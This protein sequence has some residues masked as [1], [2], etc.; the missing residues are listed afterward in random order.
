MG[1][2]TCVAA[3]EGCSFPHMSSSSSASSAD[4]RRGRNSP[5][6]EKAPL[7]RREAVDRRGS[8]ASDLRGCSAGAPASELTA[9]WRRSPADHSE[10]GRLAR[11]ERAC[12]EDACESLLARR[13]FGFG[14]CRKRRRRSGAG[15]GA[16]SA[17][18][19]GESGGARMWLRS[20]SGVAPGEEASRAWNEL[21]SDGHDDVAQL[22]PPFELQSEFVASEDLCGFRRASGL[23]PTA[24]FRPSTAAGARA[25]AA[26]WGA[27]AEEA[28]HPIL[29]GAHVER[30][31]QT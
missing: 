14:A 31:V 23:S 3:C 28:P 2:G 4:E 18:T 25:G 22:V 12:F 19:R 20:G 9:E 26:A 5:W 7:D 30:R 27:I 24:I 16:S 10:E 8:L 6:T 1:E 21:Q 11:R 17:R 15:G 29:H 13:A